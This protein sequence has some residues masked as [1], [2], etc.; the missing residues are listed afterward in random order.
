MSF[1]LL[2]DLPYKSI[3]KYDLKYLFS[4]SKYYNELL[5]SSYFMLRMG[6]KP[7]SSQS[8][9]YTER[10]QELAESSRKYYKVGNLVKALEELKVLNQLRPHDTRIL[11]NIHLCEYNL[12]TRKNDER[13]TKRVNEERIQDIKKTSV[14]TEINEDSA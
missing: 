4:L 12:S 13:Y 9:V 7:K 2:H 8:I 14:I 6:E 11:S 3:L 10:E 5:K 1:Y